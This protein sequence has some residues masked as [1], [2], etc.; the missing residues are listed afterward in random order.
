MIT[1]LFLSNDEIYQIHSILAF[2][3]F[4]SFHKNSLDDMSAM[5]RDAS[6]ARAPLQ[7]LPHLYISNAQTAGYV[8]E[9]PHD[10]SFGCL[11]FEI[12]FRTRSSDA[13]YRGTSSCPRIT[14]TS[15]PFLIEKLSISRNVVHYIHFFLFFPFHFLIQS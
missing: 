2:K 15:L 13:Q 12:F 14:S 3:I 11:I 10:L 9:D 8:Y 1:I 4:F 5:N 7:I 6:G